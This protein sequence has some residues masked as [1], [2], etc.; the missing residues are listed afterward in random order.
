MVNPSYGADYDLSNYVLND[1]NLI[2]YDYANDCPA[3]YHLPPR[4]NVNKGSANVVF[5]DG[6]VDSVT[7][8]EQYGTGALKG[9]FP[10]AKKHAGMS[11]YCP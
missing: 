11:Q 3:T 1:N 4:G 6:R 2:M 5:L 7:A 8:D 10:W 9:T